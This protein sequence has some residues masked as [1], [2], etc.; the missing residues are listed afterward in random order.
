MRIY[1]PNS[2]N[3]RNL[4]GFIRKFDPSDPSQLEVA[5]HPTYVGVHPAVLAMTACAGAA[6]REAG[7]AISCDPPLMP[8]MRYV[9]RMKVFEHLGV[10]PPEEIVDH[11]AAGRFIP[12][13]QIKTSDALD[14]FIK[15]TTPLF[16]ANPEHAE[17]VKYL[18]SELIR[19]AL[20]HSGSTVG[21]FACARYYSKT[22]RVAI[23]VAD[24]GGGIRASMA[25]SYQTDNALEAILLALRPGITGMT[26]RLGGTEYN[27]GLGLFFA[28]C[29]ACATR[30]FFV[31]YSGDGFFKLLTS[32]ESDDIPLYLDPADDRSTSHG[33]LP[34]WNG[35]VVGIDISI[36]SRHTFQQLMSIINQ[37]YGK[38]LRDKRKQSF[39]KPRFL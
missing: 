32:P 20:E 10:E 22:D 31:A 17:S 18:L 26:R 38:D 23:G 27:A 21:A 13:T 3:L 33:D 24:A 25:R 1:F 11:E 6:V 19:N 2:A 37:R 15:D 8:A 5:F 29:L 12:V 16:H 7:G 14:R 30:N 39:R 28:K 35:T 9:T 4:E 36:P 34:C